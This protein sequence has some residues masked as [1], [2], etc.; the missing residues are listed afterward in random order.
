MVFHSYHQGLEWTDQITEGI[1][2]S[3]ANDKDSVEIFVEY[4][5]SKRNLDS[6][7]Y[8]E[9]KNL[10]NYKLR[11]LKYDVIILCDDDA[12]RFWLHNRSVQHKDIP[13][14]FCGIN[15]YN[16][17][18]V[19]RQKNMTGILEKLDFK[20][21]IELIHNIHPEIKNLIIINDNKTSTGIEIKQQLKSIEKDYLSVFAFD[22]WENLP[23]SA[24]EEKFNHITQPSAVLLLTYNQDSNGVFLSFKETKELLPKGNKLP[25]YTLWRFFFNDQVIGGKVFDGFDQ[26]RYAGLLAAKI[27]AG[28]PADSLEIV[29]TCSG[30][31]VFNYPLLERFDIDEKLLPDEYMVIN[32]PLDFY[33]IN[34][35]II[36][37]VIIVLAVTVLIILLLTNAVIKRRRAEINLLNQ[38][39]DLEKSLRYERMMS[40]VIALLNSTN[41][42][43]LVI[44]SVLK[45]IINN[46][47]I[48]KVS[49]YQFTNE[50]TI[51]GVL[52]STISETGT[53]IDELTPDQFSELDHIID[54]VTKSDYFVSADLSQLT[55]AEKEFFTNRHIGSIAL[56]PIRM[57]S[58]N[59][60]MASFAR[61]QHYEWKS[62]EIK[63][64]T[65][66]VR[67]ISNAW[68][69]NYQMNKHLEAEKKQ[70]TSNRIMEKATRMASIG[71]MASG[72]THEINQPLNALQISVDSI[73]FW[74]KQH[75]GELPQL[76]NNKMNTIREGINRI[77][78]IITH[79]RE[80]WITPAT[81]VKYDDKAL[82]MLE[83]SDNKAWVETVVRKEIVKRY[84]LAE[85]ILQPV[86]LT[87]GAHMGPGTWAMAFIPEL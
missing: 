11:N 27:L 79:M 72:I 62:S 7:Y 17:T 65:T 22:Y 41:D 59:M 75:P 18:L 31:Y 56:F 28:T 23:K 49:L 74:E 58:K 68:E 51:A 1:F 32:E 36:N 69:R 34:K 85:I 30:K 12:L 76:V 14:V 46:Y 61:T 19:L 21:N 16:D 40:E 83:Y 70:V 3:F 50:I 43:T 4:L 84:P 2:D 35:S 38:R 48:G 10:F 87:S 20:S 55:D 6:A 15:N 33:T 13:I 42:F 82:I 44:D 53:Q 26:G 45:V 60:G 8:L 52:A 64:L 80:F 5:D 25:V 29:D 63:E 67:M 86:S 47:Q 39:A 77:S 66:V 24:F 81:S 57:G 54:I 9:Y 73:K 78:Q 71:V 37:L